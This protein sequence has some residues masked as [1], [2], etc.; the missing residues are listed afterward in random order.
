MAERAHP[1]DPAFQDKKNFILRFG[2]IPWV[3][4]E[5]NPYKNAFL[6]RYRWVSQYCRHTT[7]LD[8]P[9][10]MGWGT[11]LIQGAKKV[12]G[13]DI[14]EVAVAEA[15]RR[16]GKSAT[17]KVGDMGKL[18]FEDR[19]FD[20]VSCLEG[21]EHVPVEIGKKFLDESER[22]L[23]PGGILL[24]SSPFC[25]T[26]AHS[27]NPYHIHEYQPNEIKSIVSK[28][29]S[30]EEIISRGVDIMTVLYMRCRVKKL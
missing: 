27:G 22:I 19:S 1:D 10:G 13:V 5:R 29:F 20:V 4:T 17:F 9:C 12:V 18:D 21:I 24:L 7:V 30:I 2:F 8:I 6:W 26:K 25:R 14:S 15:S 16:Y 23:R 11:S 28:L 3:I